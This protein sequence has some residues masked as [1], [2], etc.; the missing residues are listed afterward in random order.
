MKAPADEEGIKP[1]FGVIVKFN[2]SVVYH[3]QKLN[4]CRSFLCKLFTA[5]AHTLLKALL[6]NHRF[7]HLSSLGTCSLA[8]SSLAPLATE[9]SLPHC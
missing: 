6:I 9:M 4:R 8:L 2:L 7:C 5:R 3:F 1:N